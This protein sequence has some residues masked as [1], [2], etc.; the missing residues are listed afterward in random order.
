MHKTVLALV[1]L[2]FLLSS[3]M[4][5]VN[6]ETPGKVAMAL[7]TSSELIT[8]VNGLRASKGLSP[9]IPNPILMQIAQTHA[10][11]LAANGVSNT[12]IDAYGR[13]PFQRALDAGYP[14]AGD[15]NLG[16]FFSENV[17][18]GIGLTAEGA[19]EIWMGDAPHQNTMLSTNLQDVGGG[20]AVVGNTYYY[21]L[22][23]G[24]STGGTP[25]VYTP[26]PY[27]SKPT[28]ILATNTPNPDGT[29]TYLVRPGDTL[30]GIAL[31]FKISLAELYTLNNLNDK[32]VIYP[33]QSI[34]VR[35]AYTATP[36]EPTG[37]PTLRPS[38][39]SWPTSMPTNRIISSTASP[40]LQPVKGAPNSAG[41]I[42]LAIIFSA[43][44]SALL[45]TILGRKRQ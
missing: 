18:G 42:V 13:K 19:V 24:L 14:V 37:T 27:V 28:V 2:L 38:S 26:P 16:G 22:D 39:T 43:L 33:N 31:A 40:T 5:A 23:A 44:F 32:S 8:A 41:G 36:T 12:H 7:T 25:V 6:A 20:V 29:I 9:Y 21:V 4:V 15:L 35:A 3:F 1:L 34:L 45:I 30:L 11:Y 17:V 10:E